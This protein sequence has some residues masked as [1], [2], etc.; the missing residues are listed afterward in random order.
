MLLMYMIID[1]LQEFA[2]LCGGEGSESPVI[3]QEQV[4]AV[5]LA[6]LLEEGDGER[7]LVKRLVKKVLP[8]SVRRTLR[9]VGQPSE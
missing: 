9:E 2:R 8:P 6:H 1:H 3:E 5:E 7:L 4:R